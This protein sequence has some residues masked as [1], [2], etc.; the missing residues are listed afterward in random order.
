MRLN[1]QEVFWKLSGEVGLVWVCKGRREKALIDLG[2]VS[3][4]C[5]GRQG[6]MWDE[7]WENESSGRM[8]G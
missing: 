6:G 7:E 4:L 3:R 8:E 1:K 5:P 2:K